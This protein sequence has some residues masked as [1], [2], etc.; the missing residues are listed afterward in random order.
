MGDGSICRAGRNHLP[1][2]RKLSHGTGQVKRKV[3]EWGE[4]ELWMVRRNLQCSAGCMLVYG[5]TYLGAPS[6]RWPE[7]QRRARRTP[8]REEQRA[9]PGDS[10]MSRYRSR[11]RRFLGLSV[12]PSPLI[13]TPT[14]N[15]TPPMPTTPAI[16]ARDAR[17]L[18]G[19]AASW[20]PDSLQ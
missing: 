13:I 2:L 5:L 7:R 6:R 17:I 14:F 10:G 8:S 12:G 9:E 4:T 15:R 11:S 18:A 20:S 16:I 19:H 1:L 3:A